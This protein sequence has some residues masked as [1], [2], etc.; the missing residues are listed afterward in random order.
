MSTLQKNCS[1][2][3]IKEI[4]REFE[5]RHKKWDLE[6]RVLKAI[7]Y[8]ART[9]ANSTLPTIQEYILA[10]VVN[11][12][13][14]YATGNKGALDYTE[15]SHIPR[16]GESFELKV[17]EYYQE[18]MQG[19]Q[20]LNAETRIALDGLLEPHEHSGARE[21]FTPY[22]DNHLENYW[23]GWWDTGICKVR[24]SSTFSLDERTLR[25]MR[26]ELSSLT[27]DS[28]KDCVQIGRLMRPYIRHDL[29][30]IAAHYFW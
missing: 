26:K 10:E 30:E 16:Y 13:V 23:K 15:F 19:E 22:D 2:E 9:P 11:A 20:K 8:H 14:E 4:K 27:K 29:K 24:M 3:E 5:E 12:T 21:L 17:L 6:R 7:I 25:E 18:Q 1:K 28:R